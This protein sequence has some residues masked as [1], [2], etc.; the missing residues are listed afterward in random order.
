[1]EIVL[2]TRNKDKLGEIKSI[3]K[4][5][6][7]KILSLTN[8]PEIPPVEEDGRTLEE[9]AVKKARSVFEYTD[10]ISLADDSGLEV[11]S[12]GGLPGIYSARFAGDRATYEANNKKLL[13]LLNNKSDRKACFRCCMALCLSKN[14]IEL[15]EGKIHG[16]IGFKEKGKSGFGYDPL[17]IIPEYGKTFAE[18]GEEIKNRISHRA[19]ALIK[20]K[21]RIQSLLG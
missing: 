16:Y 15:F 11:Y 14:K 5:L 1:M 20:V 21:K 17:F 19:R 6:D 7:V 12:L 13:K 4:D 2:A 10:K 18:L 8:F 9:N 3:L